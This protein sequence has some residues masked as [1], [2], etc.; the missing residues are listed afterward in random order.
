MEWATRLRR[1]SCAQEKKGGAREDQLLAQ[2][3][4]FGRASFGS[5]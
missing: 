3:A 2:P 4:D 1:G 5:G